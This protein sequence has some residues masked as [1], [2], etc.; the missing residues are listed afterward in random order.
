MSWSL[1]QLA[2]LR[3]LAMTHLWNSA[4]AQEPAGLYPGN[5]VLT[6]LSSKKKNAL[7]LISLIDDLPFG[8]GPHSGMNCSHPSTPT[9]PWCW[10]QTWCSTISIFWLVS[11]KQI[12]LFVFIGL[13]HIRGIRLCLITMQRSNLEKHTFILSQ[14]KDVNQCRFVLGSSN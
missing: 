10:P 11:A 3:R 7:D 9:T 2:L 8:A 13:Q 5:T 4:P 1:D 12:F 14:W 6:T